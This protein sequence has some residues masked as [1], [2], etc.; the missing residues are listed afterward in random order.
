M[1]SDSLYPL[2]FARWPPT[3]GA[4]TYIEYPPIRRLVE[5]FWG[6]GP[7]ALD[8]ATCYEDWIAL[9]ATHQLYAGLLSPKQYSSRGNQL[10]LLRLTRFLEVF[11]YFSPAHAY[12]LHVSFLG[13]FPILMSAN[14]PLKKEAIRRLEDGGLF[15]FGVSEKAHGSDLF[16]NEF[17][18]RKTQAGWMADGAKYYIGNANSA[19][20]IT[21]LARES[22]AGSTSA[23]RMPFML[24]ALRPAQAPGFGRLRKIHTLGIRAAYVGEFEVRGHP[25]DEADVISEG[26]EA[27]DTVCNTVN[28]GKFFLGFGAIGICSHAFVEA[29][30]HLRS[31]I[32]YGRPVIEMPHIRTAVVMAFARLMAMKLYAC[33]ALDYL[34]TASDDDRRYLL[35]NA[36]Q[37][38]KVSTE[39]VRVMSLLSE[40]VGARG[41]E[42][43]TYFESALRDAPLIPG[44]E[45]STHINFGLAAQFLESYFA[46]TAYDTP[47][48]ESLVMGATEPSENPYWLCARE[49]N[50]RTVRFA[51]CLRAYQPLGSVSNV[52]LFAKQVG[53][54]RSFAQAGLSALNASEDAEMSIALGKCL[55]VVAYAQLVAENCTAAAIG[56]ATVSLIFHGLI[57]D[58]SAEGLKL[59]ALLPT[60]GSERAQ[61]KRVVRVPRTSAADIASVSESVRARY[62]AEAFSASE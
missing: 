22:D 27:W 56:P 17:T 37:K 13:L 20:I 60:G 52:R 11:A 42:A 23:R 36:V 10:D 30:A 47:D 40:C 3:G 41:F 51:G 48:P 14:E 35:F 44:L 16:A 55:A 31:R 29:V 12:S 15:A 49:R 6:L 59:A 58:L 26:R 7:A 50:A 33:R 61:L 18:V 39:G 45:G 57:E 19:S 28:F 8:E 62:G 1:V 21:I 34:Q 25:F 5:F 46:D 2:S 24:F 38:A 32:L 9:Q 43:D 54:F 4:A 53:A